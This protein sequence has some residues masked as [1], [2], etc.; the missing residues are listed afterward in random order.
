MRS[1]A[2]TPDFERKHRRLQALCAACIICLAIFAG[3]IA[4]HVAN[5]NAL[6]TSALQQQY[7]QA[8]N[9]ETSNKVVSRKLYAPNLIALFDKTL[10]EA[11]AQLGEG[12]QQTA[13]YAVNE[14]GSDVRTVVDVALTNEAA[15]ATSGTPT[16]TLHLDEEGKVIR[17]GF[18]TNMS[19]L[20]YGFVSFTDA[21]LNMHV[22]EST[23]T[24]A[25][26]AVPA[27]TVVLPESKTAW[28]TYENDGVTVAL[29]SCSFE[30]EQAQGGATYLW[31]ATM[32]FDYSTSNE[33]SNLSYT[34]RM[35]T[36][37]IA[38]RR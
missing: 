29:E 18:T 16:V 9:D 35:I 36:V 15:D 26:L 11:M 27:G 33:R 30:G 4:L 5:V 13:A 1:N 22:V 32:T 14:Q 19:L 10:D 2:D 25:G 23:L 12:A 38:T 24:E 20:G 21:T 37:E 31:N 8:T 28:T 6:E 3:G 34:V 17:A 7:A